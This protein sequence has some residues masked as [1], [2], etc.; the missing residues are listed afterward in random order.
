[1]EQQLGLFLRD[2]ILYWYSAH[3]KQAHA[4]IIFRGHIQQ[5][6]DFVVRRAE[7]LACKVERE[8][9][10]DLTGSVLPSV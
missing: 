7:T 2:E 5:N 8:D 3:G 6:A 10:S 1:M 9:V 4:D